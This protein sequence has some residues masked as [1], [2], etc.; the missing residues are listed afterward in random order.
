MEQ[1]SDENAILLTPPLQYA[2]TPSNKGD[3]N[4]D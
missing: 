1:W 3:L 4:R 2:S